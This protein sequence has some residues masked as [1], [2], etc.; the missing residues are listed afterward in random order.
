MYIRTCITFCIY[1]YMYMYMYI[2]TCVPN[3]ILNIGYINNRPHKQ[4][5]NT[6]YIH[7][8]V[9][10]HACVVLLQPN[11]NFFNAQNTVYVYKKS[12]IV[13]KHPPF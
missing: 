1:M 9:N 12:W 10:V 5:E 3:V 6:M 4:T 11:C 7:V 8:H 2:C 13:K